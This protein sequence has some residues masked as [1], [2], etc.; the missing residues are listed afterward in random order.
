MWCILYTCHTSS[1]QHFLSGILNDK[2]KK[3]P[4]YFRFNRDCV[5]HKTNMRTI[6]YPERVSFVVVV[7]FCCCCFLGGWGGG[8]EGDTQLH[9]HCDEFSWGITPP[10]LPILY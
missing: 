5:H 4:K 8:G 3:S 6:L 9:P 7:F 1:K 2:I 10:P